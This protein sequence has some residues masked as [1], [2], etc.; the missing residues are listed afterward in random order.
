MKI[1]KA[2]DIFEIY[3][4]LRRKQKQVQHEKI[5]DKKNIF[6]NLKHFTV[7]KKVLYKR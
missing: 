4:I 5:V 3:I 2:C 7:I 1:L 6:Y